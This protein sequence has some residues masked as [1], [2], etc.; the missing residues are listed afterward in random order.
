MAIATKVVMKNKV[1]VYA[2][3]KNEKKFVEQFLNAAA[4]A[5]YIVVLDTGSDD[6]TYEAL[7]AD[8][9]VTR[10]EQ[11]VITP[12]RF[13]VAR[14]ESMK[15]IPEDANICVSIDFDEFYEPGWAAILREK[16]DDSKH[17]MAHYRYAWN[18]DEQGNPIKVFT[19]EKIHSRNDWTWEYPVHETLT[20]FGAP[21]DESRILNLM[22][23]NVYLHHFQD[24][25]K[26]RSSYLPL[27]ELRAE[28][29]PDDIQT[30]IHLVHEYLYNQRYEECCDLVDRMLIQFNSELSQRPDLVN[31][32]YLF[33]GDSQFAREEF[34]EAIDTYRKAIDVEPSFTEPYVAIGQVYSCNKMYSEAI[35]A[36]EA[37][38]VNSSRYFTWFRRDES[39]KDEQIYDVL[40]CC[41]ACVGDYMNAFVNIHK[42]LFFDKTNARYLQNLTFIEEHLA[43]FMYRRAQNS[44]GIV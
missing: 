42:A 35:E 14:N 37:A 28:E 20:P 44:V 31:S 1:C 21:I 27:V 10:V 38:L 11:K 12:W 32:L 8:S 23:E 22:D 43:E 36:Y 17:Y 13:D 24:R 2:I 39:Y 7:K 41:Y 5:D 4:E 18:H 6:G 25:E 34:V 26:A 3:C 16:W 19:Y 29:H 15:L 40:A 9:R 33:K 30:L